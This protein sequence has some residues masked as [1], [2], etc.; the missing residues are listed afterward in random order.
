MLFLHPFSGSLGSTV[1]VK[2]LAISLSELGVEVY[3]LTPYEKD[4][5]IKENVYVKSISKMLQRF[6]LSL[7]L[8]RLSRY[9]FYNRFFLRHVLSNERLLARISE[10]SA[11]LIAQI[12]EKFEIDIIQA[13]Q[14]VAVMPSLRAA[15]DLGIPVVADVHNIAS[16]DLVSAGVIKRKN[17]EFKDLQTLTEKMLSQADLSIVVSEEMQRYVTSNYNIREIVVVPP[18]GRPR[19][20]SLKKKVPPFKVV[21][22]GLVSYREH[23]D[24]FVRSMK[25]I[26]K[27][28]PSTN[29]FIT[30]KGEN[31]KDIKRLATRLNV[32]PNY[33]WYPRHD[34]FYKFLASCHVGVVPSLEDPARKMGTPVKLFDYLSVGLPVV[35][36]AIGA[37]TN[38]IKDEKIGILTDNDPKSFASGILKLLGTPALLREYGERGLALI[39]T[40]FNWDTSAKILLSH[41]KKLGVCL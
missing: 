19:I 29:Y 38:I 8:Y 27:E 2:E 17:K 18:G 3:I 35:A 5:I 34:E 30:R 7:S 26:S 16:E 25:Y 14:D 37:W 10:A 24:L 13:E 36:N 11:Q 9:A 4:H 33:F 12:L 39:R 32:R 41:Y 15:K 40:K 6:G 23:V 20:Q 1:R 28:V 21:Y 22:S 31:L